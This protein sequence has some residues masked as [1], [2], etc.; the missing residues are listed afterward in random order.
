MAQRTAFKFC[1]SFGPAGA[2]AV[3]AEKLSRAIWYEAYEQGDPSMEPAEKF[4]AQ[5]QQ[6]RSAYV[7][8]LFKVRGKLE[9]EMVSFKPEVKE[10]AYRELAGIIEKHSKIISRTEKGRLLRERLQFKDNPAEYQKRIQAARRVSADTDDNL[11]KMALKI[12]TAAE[13]E[14]LLK[15][16]TT[17][18][19]DG[20]ADV[21]EGNIE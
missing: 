8:D 20:T 14:E 15:Y 9:R 10:A 7:S 1:A 13:K 6:Q 21:E 5:A 19:V 11:I 12:V 16:V 2:I 18:D 3:L 4:V 17:E